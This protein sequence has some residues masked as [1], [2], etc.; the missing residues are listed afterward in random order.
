[1]CLSSFF[2]FF[3]ICK[4]DFTYRTRDVCFPGLALG[5]AW[6]KS[7][8]HGIEHKRKKGN[9]GTVKKLA[10]DPAAKDLLQRSLEKERAFFLD[11]PYV[12]F[13]P[14]ALA[15]GGI[16]SINFTM[17]GF[18]DLF[19]YT[20]TSF[21][22]FRMYFFLSLCFLFF[23]FTRVLVFPFCYAAIFHSSHILPLFRNFVFHFLTQN[24]L[25]KK[26]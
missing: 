14:S 17:L 19:F 10:N 22:S 20:R 26:K 7:V 25:A 21:F 8:T 13:F 1:V 4:S 18:I 15:G 6:R 12:M 23:H 9:K 16:F 3:Y 24:K 2:S 11:T 5:S